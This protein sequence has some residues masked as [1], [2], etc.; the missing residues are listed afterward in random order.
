MEGKIIIAK[1]T[2]PFMATPGAKKKKVVT[3]RT[4]EVLADDAR[5][6]T[7]IPIT[8]HAYAFD[9]DGKKS[10]KISV[11]RKST[12]IFPKESILKAAK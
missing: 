12:F 1:P 6:D 8:I 7:I 3:L 11:L 9:K 5:K 4:T 2:K 10:E